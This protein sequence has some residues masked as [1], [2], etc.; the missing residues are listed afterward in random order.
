MIAK[1][2]IEGEIGV[3]STLL[4][5][6]TQYKNFAEPESVEVHINSIGGS[7]EVGNA[8]YDFLKG[9][10]IPVKTITNMAYS[11]AANIFMAGDERVV[12]QGDDVLMIHFPFVMGFTGGSEDLSEM[13]KK[14]KTLENEMVSFYKGHLDIE[15]T[16]LR[17]LLSTD[18]FISGDEALSLGFATTL[19][20]PLKA[21]AY[22]KKETSDEANINNEKKSIM[23]KF[24]ELIKAIKNFGKPEDAE[25]VSL[26]L[27]DAN[28][29]EITFPDVADDAAPAIGDAATIDGEPA[30]GEYV[31]PEGET[32]VFTEGALSE[33]KPAEDVEE[34][35][36]EE[37][38]R[39]EQERL[40]AEAAAATSEDTLSPEQ[41]N[42]LLEEIFGKAAKI[43]QEAI[44]ALK[45]EYDA[46]LAKIREDN[47]AEIVALKKL[48]GSP[49]NPDNPSDSDKK[50]NKKS[51]S[52]AN[53]LR[54]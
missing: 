28:G 54:S 50:K 48:I 15:D 51:N 36:E 39:L 49:E 6:M 29:V 45:A 44:D 10:Q 19:E 41:I 4:D 53:I 24:D 34:T 21:V 25:V 16:T 52:L 14:L 42:T 26:V 37:E 9:L 33:V 23:S 20:L 27:Q 13:S 12:R 7:V 17:N 11:I 35:P 1:I 5:V 8:I 2:Y 18:T 43:N 47:E 3:D 30:N 32:W 22:F 38:A 46:R 31:S 40:D